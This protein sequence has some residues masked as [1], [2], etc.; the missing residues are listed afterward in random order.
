MPGSVFSG[1]R[2]R[3]VLMH[4]LPGTE[5]NVRVGRRRLSGAKDR[6][7]TLRSERLQ[8][9][10]TPQLANHGIGWPW[11]LEFVNERHH[12]VSSHNG[13]LVLEQPGQDGCGPTWNST[14]GGGGSRCHTDLTLFLGS[15]C[16]AVGQYRH[17]KRARRAPSR[18][19]RAYVGTAL[20]ERGTPVP[21]SALSDA[22]ARSTATER[23]H[24]SPRGL[25]RP[26]RQVSPCQSQ[27]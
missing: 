14:V 4:R 25:D 15:Y 21:S 5:L 18:A 1:E 16:T 17:R 24:R 20:A 3:G 13:R 9:P 7:D 6:P 12:V 26:D 23:P 19:N 11:Q 8:P 27:R 10:D 22:S 2:E